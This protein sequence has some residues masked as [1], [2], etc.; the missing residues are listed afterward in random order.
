MAIINISYNTV[1]KTVSCKMDDKDLENI[2]EI[3]FSKYDDKWML[4]ARKINENKDDKYVTV[5]DLYASLNPVK[6]TLEETI[7]KFI[8]NS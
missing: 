1:D 7:S 3:S 8:S 2:S 4:R 5:E 6:E